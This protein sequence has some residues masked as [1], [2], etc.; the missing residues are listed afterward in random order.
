[1]ISNVNHILK[2]KLK[3]HTHTNSGESGHPLLVPDLGGKPFCFS[4][5]RA[6]I[7]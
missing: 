5:L 1:M 6:I 4:Q 2:I 3:T 7:L